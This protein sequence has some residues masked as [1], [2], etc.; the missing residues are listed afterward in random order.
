M[1]ELS[2]CTVESKLQS[3]LFAKANSAV[4]RFYLKQIK[5]GK[6]E[7]EAE[8]NSARKEHAYHVKLCFIMKEG[9]FIACKPCSYAIADISGSVN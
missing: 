7:Q 6:S 8:V 2:R 3:I 9:R 1:M 4:K 5:T